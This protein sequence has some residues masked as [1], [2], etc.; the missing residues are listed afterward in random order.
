[1][2]EKTV[3]RCVS[4]KA[5]DDVDLFRI[6]RIEIENVQVVFGRTLLEC[7]LVPATLNDVWV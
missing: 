1:V 7:T 3:A 2:R 5:R 4:I 6:T